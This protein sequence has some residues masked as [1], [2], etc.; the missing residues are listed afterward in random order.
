MLNPGF[1]LIRYKDL[2]IYYD[3]DF[4]FTVPIRQRQ[5]KDQDGNLK[6]PVTALLLNRLIQPDV[7]IPVARE[8]EPR[9]ANACF[10][11]PDNQT[12][13]SNIRVFSPYRPTD[14]N[15]QAHL[16]EIQAYPGV[17]SVDYK[18]ETHTRSIARYF[19]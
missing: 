12:G 2:G 10:I 18:G 1:K 5:F 9:Y 11:N 3:S 14:G 17:A 13:E 15:L 6:T 16:R 4:G 7:K 8:F 19:P